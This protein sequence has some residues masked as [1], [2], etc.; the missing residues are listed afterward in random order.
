[1][2]SKHEEEELQGH[3]FS[4]LIENSHY[5]DA[6]YFL[7]RRDSSDTNIII[8]VRKKIPHDYCVFHQTFWAFNILW[9]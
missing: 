6:A 4:F 5:S 2:S 3:D 7:H 8:E 1:M 9:E